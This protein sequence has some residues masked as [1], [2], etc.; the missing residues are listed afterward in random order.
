MDPSLYADTF[1]ADTRFPARLMKVFGRARERCLH[2]AESER[3]MGYPESA[4]MYRE[5]AYDLETLGL[6]VA[7]EMNVTETDV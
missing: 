1:P 7:R 5:I 3:I 4:R 2:I 6:W